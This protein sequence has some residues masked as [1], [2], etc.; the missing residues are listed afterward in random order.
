MSL[1]KLFRHNFQFQTCERF[2]FGWSDEATEG[3]FVNVND[4][5][6]MKGKDISE[7]IN[8]KWFPG[9]PNGKRWE[10]C[11]E[12]RRGPNQEYM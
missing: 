3:S 2:W 12:L 6:D 8:S 4:K 5:D 11:M 9:E 7:E 1:H 10:N